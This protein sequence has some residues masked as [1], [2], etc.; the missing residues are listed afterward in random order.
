M[1]II[2][3]SEV[4]Y[5]LLEEHTKETGQPFDV[6][7]KELIWNYTQGQPWLV[8]AL[9]YQACFET[10]AK[11]DK[12]LEKMPI[13]EEMIID[14]KEALILRRETHLDQLA[15][16]LKEERVKRVIE[17]I[18]TGKMVTADIPEDD[19][20]YLTD[21][22]LIKRKPSI[23][24]SNPIYMEIIPRML[25]ST[26]QDSIS[27]KTLW[28]VKPDGTLDMKKLI[29]AFQEFFR[30]NSESWVERFQYKEA[31]PQ[32]LMQAFLQRVI[33]S[34]GRIEREYGLGRGRT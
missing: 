30:E 24:I 28:Y 6:K 17:P 18:I 34:G 15:D 29:S 26:T 4:Y 2:T 25:T 12:I 13:T 3:E 21:L 11:R 22:G 33:N 19:V 31:G 9:A 1:A 23:V 14:A 27:H 5:A 16:K 10:K 8:N 32:L 20:Q 7:A